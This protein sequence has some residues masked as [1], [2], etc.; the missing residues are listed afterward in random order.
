MIGAAMSAHPLELDPRRRHVILGAGP[1]GRAIATVLT[2]N[3]D[4]SA[5]PPVVVS[6]SGT[7]LPGAT[8]RCADLTDPIAAKDVLADADV[9]YQCS[10]PAYHRWPEEFPDLQDS[11]ADAA[12][13][14]GATLVV[15][16][17]LYGYGP[18]DG[19][20]TEDLPLVATGRKGRTRAEMWRD[21][22]RRHRAGDLAVV[23]A[24][25]ADFYGPHVLGSAFGERLFGRLVAGKQPE[26]PGDPTCRHS[27]AYVPD[28]A[29]AMVRLGATDD[30]WGRAWH[31]PH[32]PAVTGEHFV[33]LAADVAGV[34][35]TAS[36]VGAVKLRLAGVLIPAAREMIEMLHEF[37]RDFV[38]DD[39]AYAAR[40]GDEPTPLDVGIADTVAWY[41][42]R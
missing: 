17:N 36:S 8:A 35:T 11:I 4:A 28:V 27:V 18:V 1:V 40:F 16:E 19:P 22:E 39:R 37:D 23:A 6:R 12:A 31:V 10:Q 7:E 42:S 34:T 25:A 14:A 33:E 38:V 32:A 26:V 21:L 24:R 13:A 9:V 29:D 41:R 3:A 15:V 30:A 5:V 20:L 2:A